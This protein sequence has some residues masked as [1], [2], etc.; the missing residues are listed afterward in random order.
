[1]PHEKDTGV[2]ILFR[3]VAAVA[4]GKT[5]TAK[6]PVALSTWKS[7]PECHSRLLHFTMLSFVSKV[8]SCLLAI[9]LFSLAKKTDEGVAM[10]SS[11]SDLNGA[12]LM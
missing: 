4:K 3:L 10:N 9:S 11:S 2:Y 1:M 12:A 7:A 8:M 5:R 6:L